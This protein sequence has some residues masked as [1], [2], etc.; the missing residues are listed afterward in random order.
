[1]KL[2]HENILKVYQIFEDSTEIC[3]LVEYCEGGS[4]WD[5]LNYIKGR[6]FSEKEATSIVL[7]ISKALEV[8]H[9]NG[10]THRDIKPEN[11]LLTREFEDGV[12]PGIKL[13]DFG[14]STNKSLMETIA[15]TKEYIAPEQIKKEK[16]TKAVDMWALGII[17]D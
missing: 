14:L 9:K 5:A 13:A 16:Y 7:E 1:M 15:G 6:K 12:I 17:Y 10:I 2:T 3:Y 8:L 4:L 11:I